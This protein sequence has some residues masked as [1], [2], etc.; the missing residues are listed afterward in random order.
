MADRL[1]RWVRFYIPFFKN[2]MFARKYWVR[3]YQTAIENRQ[4]EIPAGLSG[5]DRAGP[6]ALI[7]DIPARPL[8]QVPSGR[9]ELREPK[10]VR[11]SGFRQLCQRTTPQIFHLPVR[12]GPP[13]Q[14]GASAPPLTPSI[15]A[16]SRQSLGRPSRPKYTY[17]SD[18]TGSSELPLSSFFAL[19]TR[20]QETGK[21]EPPL[22]D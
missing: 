12:L 5:S 16:C 14:V 7:K 22:P 13:H 2:S 4:S 3:F 21:R 8:P 1:R 15:I 17:T 20:P 6:N 18:R 9:P 19:V 10:S 11:V